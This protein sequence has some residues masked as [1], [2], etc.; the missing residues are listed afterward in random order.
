MTV[1]LIA[2]LILPGRITQ[3]EHFTHFGAVNNILTEENSVIGATTGGVIFGT[4]DNDEITWDSTWTYPGELSHSDCRFLVKDEEDN[5]WIATYGGGIDVAL[6]GGGFEHFRQLEGLPLRMEVTCIIPDSVIYA[7]TTEGLCIKEHGYFEVFNSQGSGLPNDMVNCMVMIDSGLIV[8]TAG[9]ASL[10]LSGEYPGSSGSWH[11]YPGGES[12]NVVD[13]AARGDSVFAATTSGLF[14]LKDGVWEQDLTYPGSLPLS[15]S[16]Y[17]NKIAVGG[18]EDVCIYSAGV[19]MQSEYG[20]DSQMI[21]A[22]EWISEDSLLLAQTRKVTFDRSTGNGVAI[23]VPGSWE[24]SCPEGVPSNDLLTC[25]VDL[26][27]DVWVGT[28]DN[29]IG[30]LQDGEWTNFRSEFP[31]RHQFFVC[32]PGK[33]GGMFICPYHEG[34]YWLDWQGTPDKSD[35]ILLSWD[36]ETTGLLNNQVVFASVTDSTTVWFGQEPYYATPDE[37]SG[38]CRF[39]WTPGIEETASWKAFQPA[40]GL[41]SGYV[42]DVADVSGTLCWMGTENG[43]ILGDVMSGRVIMSVQGLPSANVTALQ[44]SRAGDLYVGTV[45]GL[46]RLNTSTGAV[47]LLSGISGNVNTLAMDNLSCLW[48]STTEALY[49]ISPDG[50][51]EEYNTLSSPLQTLGIRGMACDSD[52]GFLYIVTDHG[53]WKLTLEAGMTGELPTAVVYPNPF[54]PENNDEVL[55]IAG[56]PDAPLTVRVFDLIGSLVYLAESG[57]R[58]EFSWDGRDNDGNTVSSGTYIIQIMQNDETHLTKLAIVR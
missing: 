22:L 26:R 40:N 8:G 14:V 39:T 19:W 43:L 45:A 11:N 27:N 13:L 35:D 56:I 6:E 34:L 5:L 23:G 52:N 29:G 7:G 30:V 15:I 37:A 44:F 17:G 58:D 28:N 38:V 57:G 25:S 31:S 32:I 21:R 54:C 4:I 18:E 24:S 1:F 36:A 10:L 49:R 51:I 12:F 47:S 41:P 20:L 50:A 53:L 2:M 48:V 42:T 16:F 33:A 55:G 3:W 9:G 46:A